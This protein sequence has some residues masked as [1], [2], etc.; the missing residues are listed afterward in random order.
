MDQRLDANDCVF[1]HGVGQETSAHL[2][3]F[4]PRRVF[5]GGVDVEADALSDADSVHTVESEMWQRTLDRRTLRISD[6][7]AQLDLD[8]DGELHLPNSTHRASHRVT[9]R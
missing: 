5:V 3:D 2:V 1:D 7:R 8:D 9:C 6:P 4:S